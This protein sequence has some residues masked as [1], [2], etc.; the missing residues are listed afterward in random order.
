MQATAP[1]GPTVWPSTAAAWAWVAPG[2]PGAG[3]ISE[4][5]GA[6]AA[7]TRPPPVM[8]PATKPTPRDT[9]TRAASPMM[10]IICRCEPPVLC[11][12]FIDFPPW[13]GPRA[14]SSAD[15]HDFRP[16]LVRQLDARV[17]FAPAV[18]QQLHDVAFDL[19]R[20]LRVLAVAGQQQVGA[21]AGALQPGRYALR[22]GRQDQ[23]RG[24]PL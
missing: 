21:P 12:S 8:Y 9:T 5:A 19:G 14:I 17:R 23:A 16:V 11:S 22:G 10:T 2:W 24:P 15:P 3:G 13:A 7:A 18:R 1:P 6:E 4:P 20:P